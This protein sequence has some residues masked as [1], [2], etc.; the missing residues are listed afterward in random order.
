MPLARKPFLWL[1]ALAL[2]PPSAPR[3]EDVIPPTI[4]I[5]RFPQGT[6]CPLPVSMSFVAPSTPITVTFTAVQW[7]DDGFG[8]FAWTDQAIDNVTIAHS[9]VVSANTSLPPEGSSASFCYIND[10]AGT[11]P[12]FHFNN[13]GLAIDV[14]EQFD[15]NPSSR[16]WDLTEGAYL[17][18]SAP[19]DV[20]SGE[21]DE[22][23]GSVGIGDG[24]GT[25]DLAQ[26]RSIS[27]TVSGLTAGDSYDLCAW[28]F[29]N[30]VKEGAPY[31]TISITTGAGPTE[32]ARK[33]WGSLKAQYR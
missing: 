28:W 27:F 16:G 11:T 2:L 9:S 1:L 12:Y 14:L 33:T 32:V 4:L 3:A 30:F 26:T 24:A 5:R 6:F 13:A 23:T 29:A 8:G 18:R 25:P 7:E 17:Q 22:S 10:P 20:S 31:L 21:G 19:H 15:T